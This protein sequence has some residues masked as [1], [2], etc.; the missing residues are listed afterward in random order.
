MTQA[1]ITKGLLLFSRGV[2]VCTETDC[3]N[4]WKAPSESAGDMGRT[5]TLRILVEAVVRDRCFFDAVCHG[6][7]QVY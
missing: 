5:A 2:L 4:L 1:T 7:Q 3:R 6:E